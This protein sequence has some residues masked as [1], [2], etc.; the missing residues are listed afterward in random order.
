[1]EDQ[2]ETKK[3]KLADSNEIIKKTKD[4]HSCDQCEYAA[5]THMNLKHHKQSKHEGIR[6]PLI[7]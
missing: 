7:M 3:R 4:V 5:T 6:K 1:M 2:S